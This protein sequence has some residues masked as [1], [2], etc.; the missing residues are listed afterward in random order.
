[1]NTD[2]IQSLLTRRSVK[3][4][5][6]TS[7]APGIEQLRLA[8]RCA[9]R[10]PVHGAVFPCRFVVIP[11]ERRAE[12][13]ELFR[14]AAARQGADEQKQQRA[15]TKALKGPQILAFIVRTPS[16]ADARESLISAGAAL[17]QFL[18][19]LQAQGFAAI[20]LSGSVLNDQALQK[21]FCQSSEE[22]LLA[23]ITVGTPEAGLEL[24]VQDGEGPF[25]VWA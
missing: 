22:S 23:W 14:A 6:L 18:L 19:A 15:A 13:A 5:H 24:Q 9:L 12:L 20:T 8:S 11:E 21:A 3:P 17:E 10:A 4:K 2:L 25:S 1:M 7:P 16:E